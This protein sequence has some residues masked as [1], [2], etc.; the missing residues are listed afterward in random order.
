ML[1]QKM[2]KER[3]KSAM[4]F[5]IQRTGKLAT[6]LGAAIAFLFALRASTLVAQTTADFLFLGVAVILFV[7]AIPLGIILRLDDLPTQLGLSTSGPATLICFV[8]AM[9]N[10]FLLSLIRHF[11]FAGR[12]SENADK[13]KS[14]LVASESAPAPRAQTRAAQ[15]K[16]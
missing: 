3:L 5:A 11:F 14:A 2:A 1:N 16:S 13:S 15:T 4:K 10:I 8:V 12:I 9:V 7:L 6:M